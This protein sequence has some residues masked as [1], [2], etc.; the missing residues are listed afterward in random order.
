VRS[1]E[2]LPPCLTELTPAGSKM[3]PPLAKVESISNGGSA[4]GITQLSRVKRIAAAERSES[5]Q[6]KQLCRQQ[7]Q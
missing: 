1:C 3:D 6:E 7:G 4:S 2:K 5:M